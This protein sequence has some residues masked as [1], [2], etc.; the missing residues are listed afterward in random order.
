M[1]HFLLLQEIFFCCLDRASFI[2][3]LYF[4]G[5]RPIQKGM[6]SEK[7]AMCE[8]CHRSL[9]TSQELRKLPHTSYHKLLESAPYIKSFNIKNFRFLAVKRQTKHQNKLPGKSSLNV[10]PVFPV[11]D[12][13]DHH[14]H[15]S[16]IKCGVGSQRTFSHFFS[17]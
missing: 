9:K 3:S 15:Q 4:G 14:E 17:S 12:H 6:T 1:Q 11:C 2:A 13:H 7:I 10:F 16:G 5:T 8:F